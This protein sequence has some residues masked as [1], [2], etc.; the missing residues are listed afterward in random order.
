MSSRWLRRSLLALGV[1]AGLAACLVWWFTHA[2]P[3][4]Y[5]YVFNLIYRFSSGFSR[6]PNQLLVETVAGLPPGRALDITMGEGRNAVYLATRGWDVTGFDISDEALRQ[7]QARAAQAKVTIRTARED[8]LR[9]DYGHDRWDLIVLSYAF[10]PVRDPE[11]ARRLVDSLKPGGVL[12]FEHYLQPPG[13]GKH[14]GMPE[15]GQLPSLFPGLEVR[16][17]EEVEARS[18]WQGRRK[19]MLARLV[20]V[21]TATR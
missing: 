4:Q 11:Y 8:S 18:D 12:V 9:F 15:S 7:A 3:G 17:H 2:T 13:A 1:L 6:E 19:A 16:R 21:K 14:L 10:A 20:A 5:R